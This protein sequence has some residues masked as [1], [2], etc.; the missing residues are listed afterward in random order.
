M[1]L[2]RRRWLRRLLLW[3]LPT[4]LT[5]F[6]LSVGLWALPLGLPPFDTRVPFFLYWSLGTVAGV[7]WVVF[8]RRP[9]VVMGSAAWMV[10]QCMARMAAIIVSEKFPFGAT[11]YYVI[12]WIVIANAVLTFMLVHL[13][14]IHTE[15]TY[16]GLG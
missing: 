14:S 8:R 3:W 11:V 7:L 1:P 16:G 12:L 4:L 2:I 6:F 13:T 15:Q 9:A 10:G 5:V